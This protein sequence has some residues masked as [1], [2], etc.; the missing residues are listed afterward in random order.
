M[1]RTCFKEPGVGPDGH[2][3]DPQQDKTSE[4]VPDKAVTQC[5]EGGALPPLA[6]HRI[7]WGL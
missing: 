1:T 3:P 4:V 6:I 5:M 7:A 2:A